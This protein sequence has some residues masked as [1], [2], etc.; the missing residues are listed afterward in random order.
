MC[1][2]PMPLPH[3]FSLV[4][5]LFGSFVW[6]V[7]HDGGQHDSVA[8]FGFGV[9]KCFW[10]TH[11]REKDSHG[12]SRIPQHAQAEQSDDLPLY[13]FH[14]QI[15]RLRSDASIEAGE[16]IRDLDADSHARHERPARVEVVGV[17]Q[18]PGRDG[19][20]QAD[21]QP[22]EEID[23][24]QL[25]EIHRVSPV[26]ATQLWRVIC[27]RHVCSYTHRFPAVFWQS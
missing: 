15:P 13:A 5:L 26:C 4:V 27:V 1:S 10:D 3:G 23:V 19:D 7:H 12:Q 24:S 25:T 20:T 16:A 2:V 18:P 11:T 17:I 9:E 22:D 21:D 14:E 8:H 6:I